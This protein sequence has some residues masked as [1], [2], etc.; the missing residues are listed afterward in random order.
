MS[1]YIVG[2]KFRHKLGDSDSIITIESVPE[3]KIK[4][5][6][7]RIDFPSGSVI[8][9][10]YSEEIIDRW[11]AGKD[12]NGEDDEMGREIY[13]ELRTNTR[14]YFEHES[15]ENIVAGL[16]IL[17]EEKRHFKKAYKLIEMDIIITALTELMLSKLANSEKSKDSV[18][19]SRLTPTL[20]N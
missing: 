9:G 14:N 4:E 19:L 15:F 10:N 16:A 20:S 12:L 7:V 8:Y 1:K 6:G 11:A 2:D 17:V 3:G 13:D 5:Y 18:D